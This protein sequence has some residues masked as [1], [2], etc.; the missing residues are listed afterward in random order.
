MIGGFTGSGFHLAQLDSGWRLTTPW[1]PV[2]RTVPTPTNHA[3]AAH[4]WFRFLGRRWRRGQ[5]RPITTPQRP[6]H[7][8]HLGFIRCPRQEPRVALFSEGRRHRCAGSAWP[9]E[10]ARKGRT[11]R[12]R[13]LVW[14]MVAFP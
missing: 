7:R 13:R 11:G 4:R 10:T 6:T 12:V 1:A 3:T 14:V 2:A 9:A 5:F 8:L